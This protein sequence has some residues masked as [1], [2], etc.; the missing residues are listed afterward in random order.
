MS[1][2]GGIQP[3]RLAEHIAGVMAQGSGDSGLLQRFQVAVLPDF[4]EKWQLVDREPDR[5]AEDAVVAMLQRFLSPSFGS[6]GHPETRHFDDDAQE[7]FFEWLE[8]L[9]TSLRDH[10]L[11]AHMESHMAKYRSLIPSLALLFAIA[12]GHAGDVALSHLEQAIEWGEFLRKHAERLYFN[13]AEPGVGAAYLLLEKIEAGDLSD[14]FTLRDVQRH[15]WKGLSRESAEAGI[16]TLINA[17]VLQEVDVPTTPA[18]GRPKT[19]LRIRPDW[20][21]GVSNS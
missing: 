9:E 8:G 7:R 1:V 3:G 18:G 5:A 19:I 20:L 17:G 13:V 16:L 15:C 10:K 6:P 14:G 11:P 12:D 21:K 4:D 2:L